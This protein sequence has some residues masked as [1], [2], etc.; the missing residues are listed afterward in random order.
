MGM[1]TC[2]I[3]LQDRCCAVCAVCKK[4]EWPRGES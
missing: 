3:E 2:C 4:L 1:P